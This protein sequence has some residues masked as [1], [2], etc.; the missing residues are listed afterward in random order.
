MSN[1]N[2][3]ENLVA[4]LGWLENQHQ[5]MLDLV[6]R[7]CDQN[8][9]SYNLQGLDQVKQML[10]AEFETLGGQLE[11]LDV[12]PQ[13]KV[14]DSG[15]MIQQPLGQAIHIAKHPDAK[16]QIML[17]I[18]MDTVYSVDHP[19]QSCVDLKDGNVNGP[20]V[21][22]AKGGL[23]VMLY[24]LRM[25][26]QSPLAGQIGWQVLINPDEELGSPGS[27]ALVKAMAPSCD[28][29]LLFE[30]SLPDGTLVS[31]RKGVGNF[32]FVLRGK[33]A[34]SG[35]EFEKGRNAIVALAKLI[36]EVAAMNTDPEVTLNVG[37][38][39]GGTALN[40][41]PDLAVGR[42][43]VRVKTLEQAARVESDLQQLAERY[44][45]VEGF[46]CE[47][48]GR[49]TSPPKQLSP[50]AQQLQQ[51]IEQCGNVLGMDIKWRGTGGASDGNKF[52]AAGLPNIDTLGP[53]GGNIHTSDEYLIPES[54]VERAK[55]TAMILMSFSESG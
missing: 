20:G 6:R 50:E 25:L 4:H 36:E 13:T 12:D 35:R 39:S 33:S 44:D 46:A 22:D 27:A 37:R 53:R 32:S 14:D 26:E 30:P 8:S 51:R 45:S 18:H 24:A 28:F 23:V 21:I 34:H 1:P 15:N 19:F 31:W 43:N 5:D 41:V 2:A 55:L 9:G 10:V 38:V 16:T 40:M 17:C 42:V 11:I 54:L 29:G 48:H 49:F 52:A 47:M 3:F 7:L